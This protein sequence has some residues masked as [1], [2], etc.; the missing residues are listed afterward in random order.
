MGQ[1]PSSPFQVCLEVVCKNRS[2]CVAFPDRPFFQL[3]WVNAYNL[4]IP[5]EPIAVA[6]PD[7]AEDVSH[8]IQC[9]VKN[10]VK[11]QARSGGHS[12]AI[13]G[14]G[15][16]DGH[17]VLDLRNLDSF[18]MDNTTW[19][20]TVGA[21]T[22]LFD[23]DQKLFHDGERAMPH[24]ICPGVGL[25]GHATI[26]GLGPS[27][28]MWGAA[29]NQVIEM[30][31]VIANRSIV[32]ASDN[33]NS[34]L[35]WA[36][37]GAGA[38]FGVVTE[39]VL[40]TH[41]AP[42]HIVRYQFFKAFNKYMDMF[43]EFQQWQNLISDP[44]LDRRFGSELVISRAGIMITGTFQ[45]TKE[46]WDTSGIAL[47]LP[48]DRTPV[49]VD[50]WLGAL[51]YEVGIAALHLSDIPTEFTAKSLA[52]TSEELL[53]TNGII[54]MMEYLDDTDPG[55]FAWFVLFD[56]SGGAVAD[57]QINATAYGHRDKIAFAQGYG[58]GIPALS[59]TTRSFIAGLF[60]NIEESAGHKLGVYPGYLYW[61]EN[62]V[63]LERLKRIWDGDDLFHNP[64][65]VRPRS[66][67]DTLMMEL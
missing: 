14:L 50:D 18:S 53:S 27:S 5:V 43:D 64:Q 36:S 40:R 28:R 41:P 51:T 48:E 30:E 20:A 17:L 62:L 11:V 47:K 9:A 12:Y 19:F 38:S 15:G 58:I 61:G 63:H 55:T 4:D 56:A 32:R 29:L 66:L 31:V 39:F 8:F 52:F 6:R 35:F 45:G 33:V 16:I 23:L 26:G 49:Y 67:G 3:S 42:Q 13:L 25:G 37:K 65:T 24:G 54:K 34:E 59:N 22:R 10:A 44:T 21:G 57:V 1:A 7:N 60:E 46:D 2:S